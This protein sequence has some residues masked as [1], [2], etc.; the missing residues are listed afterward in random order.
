M[1]VRFSRLRSLSFQLV[2]L[3]TLALLPLGLISLYQTQAVLAEARNVGRASLMERTVAAASEER[4]L[5]QEALGAAQALGAVVRSIEPDQCDAVMER[6]V[7]AFPQSIFAGF[8]KPDG[9]LDCQSMGDPI[10]VADRPMFASIVEND[11]P[12]VEVSPAGAITGETVIVSSLPVRD[13]DTVL[14]YI[15]IS[16]PHSYAEA[17]MPTTSEEGGFFLATITANGNVLAASTPLDG[18]AQHLPAGRT[19]DELVNRIGQTFISE[20]GN[21]ETRLFAVSQMIPGNVAVV[22]SLD[23]SSAFDSGWQERNWMPLIFP[24]LMWIVGVCVAY[25]GVQRLVIRHMSA[26][27]RAMRQYALG[28]LKGGQLELDNPPE[29]LKDTERAFNKMVL[30]LSH[31]EA[32]QEQDLRDKEVLLREVH[33][34][35]K[36]NLQLIAS[37]MNMQARSARTPEA[38]RMLASLQQRV[39]GLA[40]LHRTLYTKPEM[41]TVD[42]AE[43]IAAMVSDISGPSDNSE[44]EIRTDLA[45]LEL[46][47]DQAVPLSMYLAEAMTNAQKYVGHPS[48]GKPWIAVTLSVEDR[49]AR[50]VIENSAGT[51]VRPAEDETPSEDGL[52]NRLMRAFVSQLE[53]QV[54]VDRS[55]AGFRLELVFTQHDFAPSGGVSRA[56]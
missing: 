15:I 50:L 28:K 38:R 53:G 24:G 25:F 12:F 52:G 4:E 6:F 21:G 39:R 29:E 43:L 7:E 48:E 56:A 47:P 1:T 40:I 35:V 30:L 33:H 17:L 20:A 14:G 37:I 5:I 46:F 10:S 8:V 16:I 51:P 26:L 42:V 32:Q 2:A 27:R 19:V 34:R 55:E 41:A 9:L 49:K 45:P 22:G 3:L 11:G 23:V 44:V 54:K 18:A 36:N 13:G 31:A